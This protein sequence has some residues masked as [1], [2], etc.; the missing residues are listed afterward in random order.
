VVDE[1]VSVARLVRWPA[2]EDDGQPE[3][4]GRLVGWLVVVT[5]WWEGALEGGD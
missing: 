3:L 2:G 4:V 1:E 5:E